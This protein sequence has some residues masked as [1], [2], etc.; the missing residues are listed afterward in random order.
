M[1]YRN[2]DFA[3]GIT[4]EGTEYS[5]KNRFTDGSRIRFR[6]NR[7][8]KIGGWRTKGQ[9]QTSGVSINKFFEGDAREIKSFVALSGK[10]YCGIG[11]QLKYYIKDGD[12]FFDVTPVRT[13]TTGSA[14]FTST[15]GTST[16]TVN[17]TSHGVVVNDFVI[18]SSASTLGATNIT[19]TVLNQEYQVTGVPSANTFTISARDT[20]GNAVV[21]DG[22][23]TGGGGG[24]TAITY[25]INAGLN[26]F[27]SDI[28][29]GSGVWNGAFNWGAD[30]NLDPTNQLRVWSSDN[31]GEDLIACARGLD[32]YRW[33]TSSGTG[34]RMAELSSISGANLVPTKALAITVSE[35]DRHL[36]V[37]GAD[38]LN[39]DGDARTGTIDPM[40]VAFSDQENEL[41]F[42]PK[43]TNTA[44]SVRLSS[45]STIV[46]SIKNRQETVIFTDT[47]VFSMQFIGPPLTFSI[48]LINEG[49]GLIAPKACV[50]SPSGIFFASRTGFYSYTGAVR[51]LPCSV[52]D[53]VF[54]DI[55]PEEAFKCFMGINS[56]FDEMWFFYPSKTD[57]TREVSRYA[58]YNYVDNN[59]S[60]GSLVRYAWQASGVDEKPYASFSENT[61]DGRLYE[62]EVGFDDDTSVM[63][64]VFVE[65]SDI[66]IASG[67]NFTFVRKILP[68]IEFKTDGTA[69]TTKMNIVL[70]TRNQ[71]N[72]TKSTANTVSVSETTGV[73]HVRARARSVSLKFESDATEKGF[74]WQLGT[75]RL[76]ITPS[77]GRA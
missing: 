63:T 22:A 40:L 58:V 50:N 73:S 59:W 5:D 62:H 51:K 31:F 11:T 48:N 36:I 41:E 53:H 37:L 18:I 2:I 25:L 42:E 61:Q 44:G 13:T 39:T 49:S 43:A 7:V 19:G 76:D 45:G 66:D 9:V 47:S 65:S 34:T 4:K 20:D 77:G 3:S 14:T 1:P 46:G 70:Q 67:N 69:P 16:V 74:A 21:S 33:D 56:E 8:E 26:N 24:S 30:G 29:W 57:N 17:Q 52:Q 15:S 75:T 27:V 60:I 32:I 28:G 54:G 38:P 12:T 64:N 10:K 72:E 71:P 55:D 35:V 23:V 68:D 6:K